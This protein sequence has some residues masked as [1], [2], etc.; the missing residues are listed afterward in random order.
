MKILILN[1]HP[2]NKSFSDKIAEKYLAGVKRSGHE[3]KIVNVRDLKFD[4]NLSAGYHEISPLE[5]DL[6]EFQE[7]ILWCEHFVI[8]TPVWWSGVPAILKGLIDRVVLPGFAFKYKK[9]GGWDKLL[10]G[11]SSRVIYTQGGRKLVSYFYLRDCFWKT[12]KRGFLS[13][14]G[15]R[16]VR[17]TVFELAD[18]ASLKRRENFLSKIYKIGLKEK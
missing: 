2:Y 16:P 13:F 4:P 9:N 5:D 11:K 12:M 6:R 8:V 7:K 18:K 1:G 3:V 14:C 17:R 10:S 15:F